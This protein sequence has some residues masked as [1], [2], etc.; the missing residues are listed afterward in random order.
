ME[1]YNAILIEN[2][3]NGEEV[4]VG[5]CYKIKLNIQPPRTIKNFDGSDAVKDWSI[6]PYIKFLPKI[7]K[8]VTAEVIKKYN[9]KSAKEKTE[10]D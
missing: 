7:A 8:V 2:L 6:V 3:I 1:A 9:L 4:N 10:E 5:D